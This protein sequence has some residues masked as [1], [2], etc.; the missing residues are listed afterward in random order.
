MKISLASIRLYNQQVCHRC[1]RKIQAPI[2]KA[3]DIQPNAGNYRSTQE[4]LLG[5]LDEHRWLNRVRNAAVHIKRCQAEKASYL[6]TA[7]KNNSYRFA[8]RLRWSSW[9][10]LHWKSTMVEYKTETSSLLKVISSIVRANS[11][12]SF[13]TIFQS[14]AIPN[15]MKPP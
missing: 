4:S 9:E 15:F 11:S 6:E 8:L 3:V 7:A 13:S 1:L 10:E 12:A 2:Q 5:K 14:F